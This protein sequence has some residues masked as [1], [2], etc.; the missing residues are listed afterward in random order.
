MDNQEL[1]TLR[2]ISLAAV[3]KGR[4]WGILG[5]IPLIVGLYPHTEFALIRPLPHSQKSPCVLPQCELRDGS[6]HNNDGSQ[7]SQLAQ[8]ESLTLYVLDPG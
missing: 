7:G 6:W 3:F 1:C 5:R 4:H 2:E 8:G